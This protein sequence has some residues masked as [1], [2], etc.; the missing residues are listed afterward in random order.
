[1]KINIHFATAL[2]INQLYQIITGAA[3]APTTQGHFGAT[4]AKFGFHWSCAQP[5][6]QINFLFLLRVPLSL[7][8]EEE[9]RHIE[10][11]SNC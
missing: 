8:E 4:T 5:A 9:M 10:A 6:Q 2:D 3:F 11:I 7:K 1:M